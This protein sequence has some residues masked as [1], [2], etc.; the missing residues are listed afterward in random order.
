MD[1]ILS[2][3]Y[4]QLGTVVLLVD[5]MLANNIGFAFEGFFPHDASAPALAHG[6][7]VN[8][9]TGTLQKQTQ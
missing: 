6:K 8:M 9:H 3:S 7:T 5:L 4:K 1:W 2:R